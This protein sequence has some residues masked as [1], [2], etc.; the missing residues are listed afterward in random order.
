[1]EPFIS[2]AIASVSTDIDTKSDGLANRHQS[3]TPLPN[4]YHQ[5]TD[6][7]V[8]QLV[9]YVNSEFLSHNSKPDWKKIGNHFGPSPRACR[10]RY[11]RSQHIDFKEKDTDTTDSALM[12]KAVIS[13]VSYARSLQR[14]WTPDE[15]AR[16]REARGSSDKFI[17]WDKVAECVGN[18]RTNGQCR[19]KW[20]M[21]C[22]EDG[23][24]ESRESYDDQS[25]QD[26]RT[27]IRRTGKWTADEIAQ[28]NALMETSSEHVDEVLTHLAFATFPYKPHAQVRAKLKCHR[29]A[30]YQKKRREQK[31]MVQP[32]LLQMVSAYGS[33]ENADWE[34]IG[35]EV[36]MSVY[37]CQKTYKEA[38][39]SK[40]GSKRWTPDEVER[41]GKTLR[42]QK[43]EAGSY[44][45]EA[46]AVA[47]GTRT[48][49]QCY[50]KVRF[51]LRA[52]KAEQQE[53][54]PPHTASSSDK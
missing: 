49:Q 33:A 2:K 11:W 47:V 25:V 51:D 35:K 27:T 34:A 10:I 32:Q 44:D 15:V 37:L 9:D 6:T 14:R 50:S 20:K 3:P 16:L 42:S 23:P 13:S 28:L 53:A 7:E 46:V 24:A 5:W 12:D 1:M 43:A 40:N 19:D 31:D 26:E 21:L 45:W 48:K 41:L 52:R 4:Q 30:V 18:G 17:G 39:S 38:L 54:T 29:R 22:A 36:G 8:Q